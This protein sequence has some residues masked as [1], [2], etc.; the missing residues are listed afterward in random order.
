MEEI[1][2]H[3]WVYHLPLNCTSEHVVRRV[4][5]S[6]MNIFPRSHGGQVPL[7]ICH[8]VIMWYGMPE[9]AYLSGS[10]A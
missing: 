4:S 2:S 1:Y 7:G 10:R 5:N 6:N 9:D 3:I 8:P